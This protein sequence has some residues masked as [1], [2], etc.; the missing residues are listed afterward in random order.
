MTKRKDTRSQRAAVADAVRAPRWGGTYA[1][2]ARAL[3]AYFERLAAALEGNWPEPKKARVRSVI[4]RAY[5]VVMGHHH[6]NSEARAARMREDLIGRAKKNGEMLRDK[7]IPDSWR[8]PEAYAN[9]AALVIE[10]FSNWAPE[11]AERVGACRE[12]IIALIRAVAENTGGRSKRP[13]KT[14]SEATEEL[15]DAMGWPAS[16]ETVNRTRRR[17]KPPGR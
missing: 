5:G 17:R 9:Y 10:G 3:A 7:G 11:N 15:C 12:Q 2:R 14:V 16:A 4:D 8:T 13:S 6:D 1:N